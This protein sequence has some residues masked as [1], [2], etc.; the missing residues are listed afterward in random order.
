MAARIQ[1]QPRAR[2][3]AGDRD[4]PHTVTAAS[5]RGC[6]PASVLSS[7]A[8]T[9]SQRCHGVLPGAVARPVLPACRSRGGRH[10]GAPRPL[11]R[12]GLSLELVCQRSCPCS[13]RALPSCPLLR[14]PGGVPP[15]L[16]AAHPAPEG[17]HST[18]C[19]CAG[20]LGLPP[21]VHHGHIQGS[22]VTS[23]PAALV[24]R[25]LFQW[26]FNFLHSGQITLLAF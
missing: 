20:L 16:R 6:A 8:R 4:K 25:L 15:T 17:S 2:Q 26:V 14:A 5:G 10:H 19:P 12:D 21:R 3:P 22:T 18:P 7:P 23:P 24:P 9:E 13:A 1:T 11:L